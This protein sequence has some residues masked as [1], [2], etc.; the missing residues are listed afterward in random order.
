MN[1][2]LRNCWVLKEDLTFEKRDL[3]VEN[4]KFV[5]FVE[6]EE[7]DLK[8]AFVFPGLVNTHAHAAMSLF[9]GIAED[10][11]LYEWLSTYI[12]PR[13]AKLTADDVYI[14]SLVSFMEMIKN[15]ITTFVDMYF[16]QDAVEQAAKDLGIRGVITRGLA[17]VDGNGDQKLKECEDF[18]NAHANDP[19]IRG[20]VGPHALYTCSNEYFKEAVQLA[21]STN[22]LLTYHLLESPL[23]REDYKKRT[24]M[25]SVDFLDSIGAF[26]ENTIVAHG[27]HLNEKELEVFAK[28][29]VTLSYNPISNAKLGNGV[30]PI[31]IAFT[32]NVNVTLGTDSAASNNS[33]NLF[34][35]M[36]FGALI[37]RATTENATIMKMEEI[38]AMA[39]KNAA[40]ALPFDVGKIESGMLADILVVNGESISLSPS[41]YM[42]SHLVYSFDTSAIKKVM[43]NGEWVYDEGFLNV[44]F[45]DVMERFEKTVES[46]DERL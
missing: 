21:R 7:E 38:F 39:T 3:Y 14:G 12:F 41:K 9:R 27:T 6:G 1:K 20:G 25:E 33:L 37:Q 46:I 36:K 17:D 44:D 10:V 40:K 34:D 26:N 31:P 19:L 42:K 8:G 5:D 23:E 28:R 11:E 15:G 43:V 24:G 29:G 18:I 22:S 2:V 13:E 32:K 45:H 35:E 4:G 16:F 30:A